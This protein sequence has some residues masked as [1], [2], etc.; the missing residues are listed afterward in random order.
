[1]LLS[2]ADLDL[3]LGGMAL[4]LGWVTGSDARTRRALVLHKGKKDR[5]VRGRRPA[6]GFCG[7]NCLLG[8]LLAVLTLALGTLPGS[9]PHYLT[10]GTLLAQSLRPIVFLHLRFGLPGSSFWEDKNSNHAQASALD[11]TGPERGGHGGGDW[12]VFAGCRPLTTSPRTQGK[13]ECQPPMAGI[14]L[15]EPETPEPTLPPRICYQT[16]N[17]VTGGRVT[18]N[19]T[20]NYT[21]SSLTKASPGTFFWCNGTLSNCVNFSDPGPCFVV[22]V[23]PQLTLYGESELAWLLPPS[24]PGPARPPSSLSC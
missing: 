18:W 5:Q 24:H 4:K 20:Q 10:S 6:S 12:N 9:F 11:H 17:P 8:G 1:M 15:W 3:S 16:S 22:T 21:A 2:I 23:V 13:G 7:E 19:C 14:S